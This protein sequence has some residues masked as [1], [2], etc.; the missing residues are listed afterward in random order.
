MRL[1]RF[2]L[3]LA[4]QLFVRVPDFESMPKQREREKSAQAKSLVPLVTAVFLTQNVKRICIY[5]YFFLYTDSVQVTN[6]CQCA[7]ER[8]AKTSGSTALHQF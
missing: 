5:I 1:T 7:G 4:S 3:P 2:P 6:F 8:P